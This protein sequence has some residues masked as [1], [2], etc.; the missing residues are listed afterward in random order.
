[1]KL[2]V[3]G[4]VVSNATTFDADIRGPQMMK[5]TGLVHPLTFP[6]EMCLFK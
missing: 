5:P 6:V 1:M 2:C 4:E 3:L